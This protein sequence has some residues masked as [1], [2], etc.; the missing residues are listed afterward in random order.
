VKKTTTTQHQRLFAKKMYEKL[1]VRTG[2]IVADQNQFSWYALGVPTIR[3]EHRRKQGVSYKRS[4]FFVALFRRIS[5]YTHM[6]KTQ[7]HWPQ[8]RFED[9]MTE[10]DSWWKHD[11]RES[12]A[13]VSARVDRFLAWLVQRPETFIAVIS[14]GVWMETLF[15]KYEVLVLGRG[16]DGRQRRV[17]NCDVFC[18]SIVSRDGMFVRIQGSQHISG[19]GV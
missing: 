7:Q 4:S 2:P 17:H 3:I 18:C 5:I 15:A 9:S 6:L 13:D 10:D 19:R 8:I 14:H 16:S 1:L 12:V 11:E